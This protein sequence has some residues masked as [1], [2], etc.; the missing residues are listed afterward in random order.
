MN[1]QTNSSGISCSAEVRDDG[2]GYH[3][4]QMQAGRCFLGWFAWP[5]EKH[6]V[7]NKQRHC[8]DHLYDGASKDDAIA[9]CEKHF[10]QVGQRWLQP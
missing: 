1:W 7:S 8:L 4:L 3:V 6:F 9:A 5:R 2:S 10:V